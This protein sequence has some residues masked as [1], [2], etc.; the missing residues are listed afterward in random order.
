M[1]FN[2]PFQLIK[3]LWQIFCAQNLDDPACTNDGG[4]TW[5]MPPVGTA[6][7]ADDTQVWCTC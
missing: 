6:L 7:T 1:V 5:A 4:P 3:E 2:T